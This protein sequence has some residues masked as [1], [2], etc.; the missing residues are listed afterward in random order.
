MTDSDKDQRRGRVGGVLAAYPHPAA[1]L[2]PGGVGGRT[3]GFFPPAAA[4][5]AASLEREVTAG[6][7]GERGQGRGE[8]RRYKGERREERRERGGRG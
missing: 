6:G 5:A 8:G 4:V 7:G 3:F 2:R 1:R